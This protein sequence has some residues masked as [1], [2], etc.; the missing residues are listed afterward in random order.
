MKNTDTDR[1]IASGVERVTCASKNCKNR[2]ST[3]IKF[4]SIRSL[5]KSVGSG[6]RVTHCSC[7]KVVD[8]KE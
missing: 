1:S 8:S 3:G 7:K 5:G 6:D 4:G 2:K